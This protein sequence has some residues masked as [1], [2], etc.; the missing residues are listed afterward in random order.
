MNGY[1]S[2]PWSSL[3]GLTAPFVTKSIPIENIDGMCSIETIKQHNL[4]D[5]FFRLHTQTW[6]NLHEIDSMKPDTCLVQTVRN[7][8][9]LKS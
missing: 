9:K 3:Q 5:W 6:T 1:N 8:S 2:L 4:F 7:Y